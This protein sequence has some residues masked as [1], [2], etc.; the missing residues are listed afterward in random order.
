MDKSLPCG[1]ERTRT[2]DTQFRKLL[3]YPAE[4]RDHTTK[5]LKK[6]EPLLI[7]FFAFFNLLQ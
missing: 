7:L 4:L 3:F 6:A 2:S 1:P 5:L